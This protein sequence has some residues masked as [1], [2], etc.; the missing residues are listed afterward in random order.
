M[1]ASRERANYIYHHI[2]TTYPPGRGTTDDD[3][4]RHVRALAYIPGIQ[5][6]EKTK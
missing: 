6:I 5:K 3:T 1:T 4:A 2:S